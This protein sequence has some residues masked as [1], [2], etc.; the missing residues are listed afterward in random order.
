M[1]QNEAINLASFCLM[2]YKVVGQDKQREIY[3]GGLWIGHISL[4]D[5]GN[6]RPII[7]D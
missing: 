1:T 6:L 2:V 5:W 3:Y 4:Y 7:Y